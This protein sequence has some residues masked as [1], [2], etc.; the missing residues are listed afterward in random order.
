VELLDGETVIF[1]GHPSWRSI[2]GWYIKGLVLIV[3]LGAL[4]ALV[5]RLA[6]DKVQFGW[7]I[8][9]L[10]VGAALVVGIGVI[11]RISTTYTI[12]TR[13]LHIKRGILARRVQET[14]LDRVQNVNTSQSVL[15]RL[16]R[17]G[18]VDFDT[19]GTDDAEFAF[20]GVSSP[21]A[22][23]RAV[24]LAQHEAASLR[25]PGPEPLGP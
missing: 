17:V 9:A 16:L 21:N 18:T 2:L 14:R 8:V 3:L 12:T 11:K 1:E 15:E 13:R 5:T 10:L 4:V 20:A 25:A 23:V 24:G 7:V 22:V 6:G 19:A